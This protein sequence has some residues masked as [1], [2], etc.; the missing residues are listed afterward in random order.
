MRIIDADDALSRLK[1]YSPEDENWSVTGG[2]AL[3]L[4]HNAINNAPTVDAVLVTRC[5]DCKYGG[6][7]SEPDDAM[8]CLRTKDGFW[9]T[10]NDF[11][12]RG[13][14]KEETHDPT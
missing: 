5:K 7:D 11:C 10:S 8:V 4:I 2:T 9:R 14:P 1:P 13:E 6:W 12:S 3:R